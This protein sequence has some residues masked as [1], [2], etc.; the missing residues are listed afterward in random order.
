MK[1]FDDRKDE[2]VGSVRKD[3]SECWGQRGGQKTRV[4]SEDDLWLACDCRASSVGT[5]PDRASPLEQ[6]CQR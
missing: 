2:F 3:V 5:Q 4:K 1:F 6:I